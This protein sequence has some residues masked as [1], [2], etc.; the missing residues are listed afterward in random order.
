M[1]NEETKEI[2]GYEGLYSIS[3]NGEVYSHRKPFFGVDGKIKRFRFIKLRPSVDRKGYLQVSLR[4]DGKSITKKVHRLVLISFIG[5]NKDKN[6]VNHKNSIRNDNRLSNLE[7]C[8]QSE[9]IRH[10]FDFGNMTKKG[11]NSG[12]AIFSEKDVILIRKRLASGERSI[13]LAKEFGVHKNTISGIKN[14][15]NWTHI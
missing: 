8:T 2:P 15:Y 10:A 11:S 12:R 9:N 4:K 6:I 1:N 3:N 7:W 5:I 14:R 13:D